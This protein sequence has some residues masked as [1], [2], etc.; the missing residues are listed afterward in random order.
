M[1]AE[2]WASATKYEPALI[3][4]KRGGEARGRSGLGEVRMSDLAWVAEVAELPDALRLAG[5]N[6]TK[7]RLQQG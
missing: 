7:C 5:Y 1:E 6:A 2:N 3:L 4:A